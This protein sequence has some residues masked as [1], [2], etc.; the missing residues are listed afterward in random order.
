LPVPRGSI[1]MST[2]CSAPSA[3]GISS[4]ISVIDGTRC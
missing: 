4:S 1:G 3:N 2:I